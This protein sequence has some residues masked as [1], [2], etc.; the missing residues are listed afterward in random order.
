MFNLSAVLNV[1]GVDTSS[2]N[3]AISNL[4][5][6]LNTGTASAE[7][8]GQAVALKGVSLAPY[9]IASIALVKLTEAISMA[10]KDAIRFDLEMAKIAQTLEQNIDTTKLQMKY[11]RQL[12]QE[13][14][15]SAVKIAETARVIAQ[16]GYQGKE[17][18]KIVKGLTQTT[19]L[20]SF[21]DLTDTTDGLIA[22]LAQ[23]G[24]QL[25]SNN[26]KIIDSERAIALVNTIS[27][28][29]A[30][31]AE[32]LFEVARKA[33]GAFASTGGTL[34]QLFASFT[35]IRAKTRESAESIAVGIRS[36]TQRLQRSTTESFFKGLGIDLR[37]AEGKAL[38]FTEAFQKISQEFKNKGIVQGTKTYAQA[39][40]QLGG[41]LQSSRVIPLLEGQAATAEALMLQQGALSDT[42][43]DL[44][45]VQA[46]LSQQLITTKQMFSDLF[47]TIN[48]NPA[49][50][51]FLSQTIV[52]T[53]GLINLAKV[54]TDLLP[55]ILAIST[56]GGIKGLAAKT[57]VGGVA[58]AGAGLGLLY[59]TGLAG[60]NTGGTVSRTRGGKMHGYGGGDRR[61]VLVEDGE[62]ILRKDVAQA[63]G[64]D[65]LDAINSGLVGYMTGGKIDKEE[66][67]QRQIADNRAMQK[68]IE[69]KLSSK[70]L[71]T[72]ERQKLEDRKQKL[73]A[74][75]IELTGSSSVYTPSSPQT[76]NAPAVTAYTREQSGK[77][78]SE[79]ARE[80][81][82]RR[83]EAASM[84]AKNLEIQKK[85]QALEEQRI[86]D[87]AA[88]VKR[89][90][91]Q[92]ARMRASQAERAKNT[93]AAQTTP[94]PAKVRLSPISATVSI[95]PSE[96]AATQ[97]LMQRERPKPPRSMVQIPSVKARAISDND[98]L[99]PIN[100]VR[101]AAQKPRISVSGKARVRLPSI[102]AIP[103]TPK[104]GDL[105]LGQEDYDFANKFQNNKTKTYN[106]TGFDSS[107]VPVVN[108]PGQ[109]KLDTAPPVPE[110]PKSALAQMAAMS[111]NTN[112][113]GA[114]APTRPLPAQAPPQAP[115]SVLQQMAAMSANTNQT[116]AQAPTRPV[117]KTIVP[118]RGPFG[119]G[120]PTSS[121]SGGFNAV[122]PSS[123]SYNG[124]QPSP[125][126]KS[127]LQ[128]MASMTGGTSRKNDIIATIRA[129]QEA[130]SKQIASQIETTPTKSSF[131]SRAKGFFSRKTE[132]NPATSEARAYGVDTG[133]NP[134]MSK[135][136]QLG[137][138]GSAVAGVAAATAITGL[139]TG[140]QSFSDKMTTTADGVQSSFGKA[141]SSVLEFGKFAGSAAGFAVGGKLAEKGLSAL[142]S[143]ASGALGGA[144]G[145][146]GAK[147]LAKVG[148]ES[149][150]GV[151]RQLGAKAL[152][153]G[154]QAAGKIP[155]VLLGSAIAVGLT[156]AVSFA[157]RKVVGNNPE[158]S[159]FSKGYG[160][161]SLSEF[162]AGRIESPIEAIR[163]TMKA[164]AD[165]EESQK[166]T[167]QK[168][169]ERGVSFDGDKRLIKQ[170]ASE[171]ASQFF[172]KGEDGKFT[173]SAKLKEVAIGTSGNVI[174]ELTKRLKLTGAEATEFQLALGENALELNNSIAA[175]RE[176]NKARIE[177]INVQN[178]SIKALIGFEGIAERLSNFSKQGDLASNLAGNFR[179][180]RATDLSEKK[181]ERDIR[182]L[183][184]YLGAGKDATD[185]LIAELKPTLDLEKAKNTFDKSK[186]TQADIDAFKNSLRD[187]IELDPSA[188]GNQEALKTIDTQT[189]DQLYES[190]LKVSKASGT[191]RDATTQAAKDLEAG[192]GKMFDAMSRF[193]DAQI[194]Y[195][196]ATMEFAN[197]QR[198]MMQERE[199]FFSG[200]T[201]VQDIQNR[202]STIS[203]A[204]SDQTRLAASVAA[205]EL[206]ALIDNTTMG[207]GNI[208]TD[209]SIS[210]QQIEVKKAVELLK[211]ENQSRLTMIASLKEEIEI[212]KG[213]ASNFR[214]LNN[215]L[216]GI[217]GFDAKMQAEAVVRES[218]SI[219]LM[220]P[221]A[222]QDALGDAA[223]MGMD[224]NTIRGLLTAQQN[225][226]IDAVSQREGA[227]SF[228]GVL[229]PDAFSSGFTGQTLQG[230]NLVGNVDAL[231]SQNI[232]NDAVILETQ[233]K[234]LDSLALSSNVLQQVAQNMGIQFMTFGDR[235][236]QIVESL[237]NASIKL[238][239][240]T[241]NVVVDINTAQGLEL[242]SQQ[243]RREMNQMIADQ[244]L[245]Q[246]QGR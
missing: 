107:S 41:V 136:Y 176:E 18:E 204:D 31:E 194:S 50:N 110:A 220:N 114:Q 116:G 151:A 174:D 15:L 219:A 26:R 167:D 218:E 103:T 129:Q 236:T 85:L 67:R 169:T 154:A 177:M 98:M 123:F 82:Q 42:S 105:I 173:A 189:P 172:T 63:I 125:P 246:Q 241:T 5:N 112:Q 207:K 181:T 213:R 122:P 84:E 86:K 56:V 186:G 46:T 30:V 160:A 139:I 77:T 40:E 225:A 198:S 155:V 216:S 153:G 137:Q 92:V 165:A 94:E 132:F 48:T 68:F 202:R 179:S 97:A 115:K 223:N 28:K 120:V 200:G 23:F 214:N 231:N 91:D 143:A 228:T 93:A 55:V 182:E 69:E 113:T 100:L 215:A 208:A 47:D 66:E 53:K 205:S 71:N 170:S 184:S 147:L 96:V 14:G 117:P 33:G 75:F 59:L 12:S 2:I 158:N 197:S 135:P 130:I 90:Q 229:R 131:F 126:P 62:F 49:F 11:L 242:I 195:V 80:A 188:V 230:N 134:R 227:Q 54:A 101:P 8:F 70:V 43:K 164:R 61:K 150:K 21:D 237:N 133:K 232:Q 76:Y 16:A 138:T 111:A 238:S 108:Y 88:K 1:V 95:P 226:A 124:I 233:R 221:E 25:D 239:L 7:K 102:S 27:K 13:Y 157:A 6:K 209:N 217:E 22:I 73:A 192:T 78:A 166:I 210:K 142:G 58:A 199:G 121:S 119:L 175:I 65:Q 79:I 152:S 191:L 141:V 244:L 211:L 224:V 180:T 57:G 9:T 99:K 36:I 51:F 162:A 83:D 145:G 144:A 39:V 3:S 106:Q 64:Y 193:A 128:Q 32:D 168:A 171:A 44:A 37:D 127:A 243:V 234:N 104:E 118:S 183:S 190:A 161:S 140:L 38:S 222:A 4:N 185:A 87:H 149:G 201:T 24:N 235:M 20:A 52:L 203:V 34:E 196:S 212:E 19:L 10:T 240:D 156:E 60:Y 81:K 109:K 178:R 206:S 187:I 35:T 45:V 72:A 74:K 159:G 89:S 146:V 148:I 29:Y 17:L 163:S 245:A